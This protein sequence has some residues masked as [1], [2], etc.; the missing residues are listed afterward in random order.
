MHKEECFAIL[1]VNG[2]GKSTC[3][4]VLTNEIV[5]TNGQV[6]ILGYDI[7]MNRS[8]IAKHMG[9]CPQAD[10]L[11]DLMTV[12]EHLLFYGRMRCLDRVYD[13]VNA[14]IDGLYLQAERGKL[15][16]NLSGGNK[17]KLSVGISLIGKSSVILLDEPSSGVDP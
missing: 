6:E 8:I 5:M 11:F 12:E 3:F 14:L 15:S 9:Y 2:A 4:K 16:M 10:A 1:G 17:R 7:E 13:H